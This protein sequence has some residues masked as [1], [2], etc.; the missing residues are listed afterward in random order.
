[1]TLYCFQSP[2]F[3]CI[4]IDSGIFPWWVSR[5][6]GGGVAW[7]K[8]KG[9]I[10]RRGGWKMKGGPDT[11]FRTM[12]PMLITALDL[13]WLEVQRELRMKVGSEARPN[14][15]VWFTQQ[16]VTLLPACP[17]HNFCS[18]I[19][20]H[21]LLQFHNLLLPLR[22]FFIFFFPFSYRRVWFRWFVHVYRKTK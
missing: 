8:R 4:I 11:P 17:F 10:P 19:T 15:S 22:Q 16:C 7:F 20:K 18:F 12:Y 3:Q 6:G 2:L 9:G 1:M 13:I 5:G 14:A 21:F